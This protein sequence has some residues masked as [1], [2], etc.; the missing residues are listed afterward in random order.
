MVTCK[1]C[2]YTYDSGLVPG[3]QCPRCLLLGIHE[4]ELDLLP[5]D[6]DSAAPS[7]STDKLAKARDLE[8]DEV[9]AELPGFELEEQIGR[10]G[11]GVVWRARERLLD[12]H[13][14]IKLL[15]NVD[16]DPSFVERFTREARVM[17]RLNHPNVVTLY[18]FGRT[19][20]N[21]CYMVMELIE[22]MDLA[23]AMARKKVA[24]PRALAIVSEVCEALE[25][26]HRA[27]FVHRDMKPGNVLTTRLGDIAEIVTTFV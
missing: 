14:A 18:S 22:G 20:S 24:V 11:M 25:V 9:A 15:R 17:A 7:L 13:V 5:E 8:I 21:H 6:D 12:R 3:G 10:G 4:N 1:K 19:R 26:A 16:N 2:D 23:H 27:G